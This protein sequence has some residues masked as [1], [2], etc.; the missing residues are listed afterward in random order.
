M[1]QS[2]VNV[3]RLAN[4]VVQQVVTQITSALGSGI[5]E[6]MQRASSEIDDAWRAMVSQQVPSK[7]QADYL[8]GIQPVMAQGN[9][10]KFK[11]QGAAALQA[12][13]GWAPPQGGAV[14]MMDGLGT[15]TGKPMDMRDMLLRGADWEGHSKPALHA[16]GREYK[17]LKLPFQTSTTKD[18]TSAVHEWLGKYVKEAK[19]D[20]DARESLRE[21]YAQFKGEV[22]RAAGRA[23]KG[24]IG[25]SAQE[26]A[27]AP[28]GMP[29]ASTEHNGKRRP[30]K[31]FFWDRVLV[32][33]EESA[34]AVKASRQ[35]YKFSSLRTVTSDDDGSWYAIGVPPANLV[36]SADGEQS[37]M[38]VEAMRIIAKHLAQ[39][40]ATKVKGKRSEVR[41]R[42]GKTKVTATVK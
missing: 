1:R 15:Y 5:Q 10:L 28:E 18:L 33:R 40:T 19:L 27:S 7:Y 8:A 4:G 21:K 26:T 23:W 6:A 34:R 3:N 29:V 30:H 2:R 41:S 36:F 31:N 37:P 24:R 32:E 14:D 12:E 25:E 11:L 13:L 17:V 22:K 35:K 42:D 20:T 39:M 38:A 9:K 16:N